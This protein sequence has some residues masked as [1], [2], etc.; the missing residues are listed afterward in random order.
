MSRALVAAV[1]ST[2]NAACNKGRSINARDSLVHPEKGLLQVMFQ[3]EIE[4]KNSGLELT[5]IKKPSLGSTDF[6]LWANE[7]LK[8]LNS[9]SEL[10][11]SEI[12]HNGIN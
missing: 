6:N 1:K 9:F 4:P 10:F 5:G 7:I 12:A 8:N 11:I 2:R 3:L